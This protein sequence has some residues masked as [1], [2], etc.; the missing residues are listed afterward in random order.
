M[1]VLAAVIRQEALDASKRLVQVI[2]VGQEDHPEV[3]GL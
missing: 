3:I 1:G 2:G